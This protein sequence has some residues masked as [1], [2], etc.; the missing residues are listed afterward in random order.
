M[1]VQHLGGDS[2]AVSDQMYTGTSQLM[3]IDINHSDPNR[4]K[5]RRYIN[6]EGSCFQ[7][8]LTAG[9]LFVA[10]DKLAVFDVTAINETQKRY[11]KTPTG[12]DIAVAWYSKLAID[13]SGMMWVLTGSSLYRINP[14]TESV[15]STVDISGLNVNAWG[16]SLDISP[17]VKTIYF[18]AETL[19]YAVDVD[20]IQTPTNPI[21]TATIESGHT[22]YHMCVSKENTIFMCD[23]MYGPLAG[24]SIY[25]FDHTTGAKL[26]QFN[27]GLFPRFIYFM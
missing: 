6:M 24:A 13:K 22:I 12:A 14:Q 1:Y 17:D 16:A 20:N 19:V 25:E 7:M 15:I 8:Q 18:N 4:Q 11:I 26:K 23:V 21:V 5:V 10:G 27:V 2:I 3:I 9:K